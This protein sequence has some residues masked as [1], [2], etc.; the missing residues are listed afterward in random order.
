MADTGQAIHRP[1]RLVAADGSLGGKLL[2][3]LTGVGLLGAVAI[4]VLLA[5]VIMPSFGKLE[6]QTVDGHIDRT[7]VALNEY[8]SKVESSVRDYGDWN[9]SYAYMGKPSHAFEVES[10]STLAL[11][12]LGANGM[13]YVHNDGRIQIVRWIGLDSQ[14]E[15]PALRQRF[16]NAIHALN[17][18]KVLAGSNSAAFYLKLGDALAAVGVAQVRRSDGS[19][20]PRGY[21]LIARRMTSAQLSKLLQLK[22]DIDVASPVAENEVISHSDTL[23]IAVPVAGP[24]GV[25]VASARFSVPRT[26]SIL[27][28]NMLLVAV[29]GTILLLVIMLTL[30]RRMIGRLVLD[31]LNKVEQHMQMVRASGTLGILTS[32]D[33]RDEIGSLVTS[34]NAMLSQ[35]KDL[36]E[37]LEVQ[38]FKLGKSES[39]VAVM[40]NVRNALNPISTILSHGSAKTPAVDRKMLD[41]AVGELARGDIDEA[42][43]QKL[44]TFV[45][46]ALDKDE[47]Q[48]AD[49]AEQM[50]VGRGALHNVL[51]IIGKQQADA[52]ARPQLET[53]DITDIIAQNAT[54]ARYSGE[55]SIAFRFPSRPHWVQAN[56]VLLSQVIGNLFSNAAEAIAA[57]DREGGSISVSVTE[58]DDGKV[59]IAIQDDGEGFDPGNTPQFFQRGF[60]TRAHK[61]GG[62]GLHWCANSMVA[63]EG[64]L[65]LE[66]EGKGLGACAILTVKAAPAEALAAMGIAA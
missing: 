42:R 5:A 28:R 26:L 46:A 21:V 53:C 36:R 11:V 59:Q 4:T 57:S 3:I 30:L 41:R 7:H 1:M 55:H 29:G 43:R 64:A 63:M 32:I 24:D 45:T 27:G 34:F 18:K 49:R 37:Q 10:F 44:A 19:G 33:R 66:S 6:R 50:E 60:S 23:D 20:T 52:H 47:A 25:P 15:E 48:R 35:L 13:A 61:S 39:A 65:D 56:R 38:S 12:N 9:S 54:I 58:R 31:P 16:V 62:L 8:A 22:A 14:R 40:H 51:E 2:L 17:F